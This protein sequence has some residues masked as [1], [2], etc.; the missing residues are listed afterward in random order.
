MGIKNQ[1]TATGSLLSQ[2]DGTQPPQSDFSTVTSKL[3][4]LYSING[5][6]NITGLP[7]PSQLDLNG[8]TP[9]KYLDNPPN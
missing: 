1:L 4:N 8:I 3:H 6:P 2:Y 5:T 9:S 7:T